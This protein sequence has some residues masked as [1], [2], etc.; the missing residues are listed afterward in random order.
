MRKG[1]TNQTPDVTRSWVKADLG[2]NPTRAWRI[3]YGINYDIERRDLT[4][5]N[6]SVYRDL[7]CW[8]ARFSWYP[9]GFNRGFYFRINI[10]GIPQIKWEYREGGYGV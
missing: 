1:K 2:F 9:T 3:N 10:K 6:M 7:H 4:A 5:Q 8:E